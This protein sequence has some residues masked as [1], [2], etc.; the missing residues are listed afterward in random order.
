MNS[1][2]DNLKKFLVGSQFLKFVQL[3]VYN[4]SEQPIDPKLCCSFHSGYTSYDYLASVFLLLLYKY[5]FT[6]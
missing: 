2:A 4:D 6:S 3:F 1:C 5:N